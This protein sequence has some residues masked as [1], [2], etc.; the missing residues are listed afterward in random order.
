MDLTITRE[1]LALVWEVVHS[2]GFAVC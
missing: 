2:L 1:Y